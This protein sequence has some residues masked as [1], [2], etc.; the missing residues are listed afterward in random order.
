MK[1]AREKIKGLSCKTTVA[2][3]IKMW[4]HKKCLQNIAR[5]SN[6]QGGM[7][8]TLS[9]EIHQTLHLKIYIKTDTLIK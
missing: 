5:E 2:K 9:D 6:V 1:M 3:D 4:G 8:Y 7:A